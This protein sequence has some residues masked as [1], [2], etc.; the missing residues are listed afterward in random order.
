MKTLRITYLVFLSSLF[1]LPLSAQESAMEQFMSAHSMSML[2][3]GATQENHA[4]NGVHS[5]VYTDIMMPI[6]ENEVEEFR[7][8]GEWQY[9]I[10][11]ELKRISTE[12]AP[13]TYYAD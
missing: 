11:G 4:K 1:A 5:G 12:D 2:T 7:L 8:S 13:P 10:D 6:G 9:Y 3:V